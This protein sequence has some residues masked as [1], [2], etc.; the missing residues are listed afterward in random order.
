MG[1]RILYHNITQEKVNE[2]EIIDFVDEYNEGDIVYKSE[3]GNACI[4]KITVEEMA[5]HIK[6]VEDWYAEHYPDDE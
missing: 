4:E 3:A 2:T 1:A 6:F 5:K